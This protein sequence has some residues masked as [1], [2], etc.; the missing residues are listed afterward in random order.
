MP[1]P[2]KTVTVGG[3]LRLPE[4]VRRVLAGPPAR[5]DGQEHDLD[6]QLVT[7]LQRLSGV[8]VLGE[9]L[10]RSR[11]NADENAAVTG[12]ELAGPVETSEFVIPVGDHDVPATLYAPP[13]LPE[14]AGLLVFYHGGG[15]CVG[16]RKSHDPVA[17]FL[18]VHAG[19]RVLSVEYRLAPENPFPAAVEDAVAAFGYA[20]A[21]ASDLGADPARIAVGGDSAGGNLAAVVAQH[22]AQGPGPAPAFQLLIYPTTDQTGEHRSRSLFAEGFFL[23]REHTRW[24]TANYV[25][26]GVD[27]TDPRLSPLFGDVTGVA[28][29][30]VATAGFD[31]LRDEG[32][33]YAEKLSAAGIPVSHRRFTDLPH[34]YLNFLGVGSRPYVATLDAAHALRDGLAARL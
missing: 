14:D 24:A 6:V 12:G 19:V 17:R 8:R 13:G 18:A 30:Y 10:A 16:S 21:K 23:T 26:Q 9:P 2:V 31:P 11:V 25:P 15:F 33:A 32:D 3:A 1:V 5:I 34:G 7:R 22:T 20:I 29:A 27:L 4:R 28:P